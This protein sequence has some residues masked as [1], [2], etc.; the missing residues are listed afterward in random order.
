MD[1][2][3]VDFSFSWIFAIIAG[4]V[5][6]FSAIYITSQLIG[7]SNFQ[8][9]TLVAGELS[10][11]LNPVSTNLEDNKYSVIEF[12]QETRVFNECS[13]QGA[14]GVQR[15]STASKSKNEWS[16]QSAKKS[17]YNKYVFSRVI[18]ET[19]NRELNVLANSVNYPFKIGDAIIIY[20]GNYCFVNPVSDV[21]DLVSDL[22]IGDQ[23]IG[24]NITDNLINCPRNS[25][26]VCF[27]KL[28]C[29]INVNTLSQVVTKNSKGMYY[30]GDLIMAAILSDPEI[31]EC[32]LKRLMKRAS[33]LAVIY[34]KK[35]NYIEGNGCSNN[36]I[37]DLQNFVLSA[38]IT[39][40]RDF[41]RNIIPLVEDLE[42]RNN[43]LGSCKVF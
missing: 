20:S 40:S 35:A 33:E 19:N 37:S 4:A 26:I 36:L 14:F 11:L 9:D 6:L 41:S 31:Y 22:S 39:D 42:R 7:S 17:V 28:G 2:K 13:T 12:A 43:D 30:D 21:E 38:N 25:T 23:D 32:Q 27:N 29:D 16:S 10:N 24:I 5:I 18:E 15:L 3:G 1:K 34:G 8:R